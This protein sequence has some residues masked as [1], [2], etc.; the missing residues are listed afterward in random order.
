ADYHGRGDGAFAEPDYILHAAGDPN[1][2]LFGGQLALDNTGHLAALVDAAI[3]APEPWDLATATSTV[4]AAVIATGIDYT[5]P[6]LH[7]NIWLNQ[8]EIPTT[9][10]LA[11][12]DTDE[13]GLITFRDLNHPTNAGQVN[14]LNG[15]G[16]RDGYDLLHDGR[17]ADGIDT[18]RNGKA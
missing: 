10:G 12:V 14:D 15:N 1:D 16:R 8:G 13:D 9:T 3:D 6:D 17:W 7:L 18:D 11:P 2:P 4:P 5:H